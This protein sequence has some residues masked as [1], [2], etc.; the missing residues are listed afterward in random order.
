MSSNTDYFGF[1]LP[2]RGEFR[3]T[4]D[5]IVNDNMRSIDNILNTLRCNNLSGTA[6]VMLPVG[7][8]WYSSITN[9]LSV[10]TPSGFK[11]TSEHTHD[12]LDTPKI[13]L[14]DGNQVSGKLPGSMIDALSLDAGSI[15]GLTKEQIILAAQKSTLAAIANLSTED[16]LATVIA[17]INEILATLRTYG[18]IKE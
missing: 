10:K 1:I 17:K 4:W 9:A 11:R 12:G 13:D 2:G 6:N 14:T 7:S 8:T 5:T 15:G 18:V 16:N 3:G